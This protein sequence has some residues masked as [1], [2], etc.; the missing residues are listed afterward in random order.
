[1]KAEL[2]HADRQADM[3][4]LTVAFRK[5]SNAPKISSYLMKNKLHLNLKK[6]IY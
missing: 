6:Y 5:F 2:L 3:T 1:M 4:K